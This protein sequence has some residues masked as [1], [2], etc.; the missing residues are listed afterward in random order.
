M[1]WKIRPFECPVD[2][3]NHY[4][5]LQSDSPFPPPFGTRLLAWMDGA[6]CS[7]AGRWISSWARILKRKLDSYPPFGRC[8]AL[9]VLPASWLTSSPRTGSHS[10]KAGGP[11][12]VRASVRTSFK[13]H[14]AATNLAAWAGAGG[15]LLAWWNGQQFVKSRRVG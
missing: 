6:A 7:S 12:T 9:P 1:V 15:K 10:E 11:S 2:N 5:R 3:K 14:P 8:I 4:P 13:A